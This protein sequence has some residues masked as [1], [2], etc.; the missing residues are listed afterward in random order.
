MK[1]SVDQLQLAFKDWISSK[2]RIDS[3]IMDEPYPAKTIVSGTEY[4][5]NSAMMLPARRLRYWS[6]NN[7]CQAE[8]ELNFTIS[9]RYPSVQYDQLPISI[10]TG[11]LN[12]LYL[13]AVAGPANI[14]GA[15]RDVRTPD[16]GTDVVVKQLPSQNPEETPGWLVII[17]PSFQVSY[18][19]TYADLSSIQPGGDPNP[20]PIPIHNLDVGI[21]RSKIGDLEDNELDRIIHVHQP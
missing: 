19:A 3:W 20:I 8:V 4:P 6:Q 10:L 14:N 15:I 18:F 9:Y 5:S 11:V 2:I 12:N 7:I 21:Y 17:Q 13:K 16:I 1:I